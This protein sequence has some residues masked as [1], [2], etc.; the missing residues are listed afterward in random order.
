MIAKAPSGMYGRP[1]ARERANL[2]PSQDQALRDFA[3]MLQKRRTHGE[4]REVR[5]ETSDKTVHL[6]IQYGP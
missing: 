1:A 5:G 4:V 3:S 6:I 2:E